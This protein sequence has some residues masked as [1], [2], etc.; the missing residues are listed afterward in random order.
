MARRVVSRAPDQHALAYSVRM[1]ST[2][3]RE[4][5]SNGA[6]VGILDV[7]DPW[8]PT[9]V[10]E[11][12][13]QRHRHVYPGGRALD[14]L[15]VNRGSETL[16]VSFHG[17]LN[18]KIFTIPR[19][20]RLRSLLAY[21]VSSLYF[22]DPALHIHPS[23]ELAWFTGWKGAEVH[24]D[25]ARWIM[26]AAEEIGARDIVL[27]GSSGGGFAA[28]MLA[29]Y[30]PGSTA[31]VYS[32]Q[33][34][35]RVYE[36]DG[37]HPHAAK[38]NYLRHVWPE[39][40]ARIP[41]FERFDFRGDWEES[42]RDRTSVPARFARPRETRIQFVSNRRDAHH[43]TTQLNALREAIGTDSDRLRVMPYDGP[44]GHH[45]PDTETFSRGLEAAAR[46][47]GFSLPR[48]S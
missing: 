32:P 14:S 47:T 27:T 10:P 48:V 40:A 15:L 46:W 9:V 35:V 20:E 29:T 11:P 36:A 30:I 25:L 8:C 33:V 5:A 13:A 12:G 44:A 24:R 39:L 26:T 43:H 45:P 17:A 4:L 31:V 38:R 42:I 28:M 18:R 6:N 16:V 3:V 21:R 41:D 2:P 23:L 1:T 37:P 7:P 34:D 19:F 22:S